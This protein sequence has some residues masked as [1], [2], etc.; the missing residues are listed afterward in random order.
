ME[1][2]RGITITTHQ[3]G[4]D[5]I[6]N[7]TLASDP[8]NSSNWPAVSGVTTLSYSAD[9][10]LI[11][12]NP[13]TPDYVWTFSFKLTQDLSNIIL[14]FDADDAIAVKNITTNTNIIWDTRAPPQ[15]GG[16]PTYTDVLNFSKDDELLIV[17]ANALPPND[18]YVLSVYYIDPPDGSGG[19]WSISTLNA[20]TPKDF[21][22]YCALV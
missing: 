11:N 17:T 13:S 2:T 8:F 6:N 18:A 16:D 20:Q 15:L 10:V 14:R 4:T 12:Y 3:S 5:P 7:A 9:G 1:F 19:P 22:V 21:K